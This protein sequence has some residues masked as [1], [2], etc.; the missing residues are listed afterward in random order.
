MKNKFIDVFP[1]EGDVELLRLRF[2]EL[3]DVASLF[4]ISDKSKNHDLDIVL[5][6]SFNSFKDKTL[7]LKDF[8]Y[9][10][11]IEILMNLL[12]ELD[13]DYEDI[14]TLS[15]KDSI[16]PVKLDYDLKYYLYYGP[17]MSI[18]DV[19][20]YNERQMNEPQE[21]GS[22]CMFYH[23]LKSSYIS[24]ITK[25]L[26]DFTNS[27]IDTDQYKRISGGKIIRENKN[28]KP[29]RNLFRFV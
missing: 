3:Q 20:D 21:F 18:S 7:I 11:N 1:Y 23:H 16:P 19:F 5:S 24:G 28:L 12:N 26:D 27:V 17:Q 13:L 8:D 29:L 14:I 25:L 6:N 9:L 2:V 15:K 4:I 22:L 10:A